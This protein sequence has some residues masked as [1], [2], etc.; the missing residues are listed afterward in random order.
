M[1]KLLLIA[2][3]GLSVMTAKAVEA[4]FTYDAGFD[5]VSAYVWRG[6]YNGGLSFQP[7]L[8]VGY[9]TE[10]TSFSAG[11]WGSVGASDWKFQ[12]GLPETEDGNPNTY[13]IP[14]LDVILSYSFYGATIGFTHYYYCDGGNFFSWESAESLAESGNGSQTE[15]NVGYTLKDLV[16]VDF[17][18]NWNTFIAGNDLNENEDGTVKRA[19]SSYFELGYN[20]DLPLGFTLGGVVGMSPWKSDYYMNDGFAVVNIGLS[21]NKEW[22]T[23]V[24]TIDL[25]AQGSLNP[26]GIN[27]ENTYI[28]DAGDFKLYNQ[29]LNGLIGLGIWF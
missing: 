6:M 5:V 9:E 3:L 19:Y 8:A 1:K 14:E 7:N 11:V 15:I 27:K 21:L 24:C 16:D 18:I 12:K 22:E 10:N 4:S 28:K 17:F 20:H 13:F 29:K 25:Y 26:D 23:D 2:A